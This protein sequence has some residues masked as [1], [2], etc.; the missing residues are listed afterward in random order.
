MQQHRSFNKHDFQLLQKEH[1][2]IKRF[3]DKT[4][5]GASRP[6]FRDISAT[7]ELTSAT[8]CPTEPI[9]LTTSSPHFDSS[10]E[11]MR[12]FLKNLISLVVDIVNKQL[13]R[14]RID[15]FQN[16]VTS[17]PPAIKAITNLIIQMED[18]TLKLPF[19]KLEQ[20]KTQETPLDQ[21]KILLEQ[22][23]ARFEK[24]LHKKIQ[25]HLDVIVYRMIHTNAGKVVDFLSER[26]A[27]L[28]TNTDFPQT[29]DMLWKSLNQIID[30]L[31]IAYKTLEEHQSLLT[32]AKAISSLP[33]RTPEAVTHKDQAA[34]FLDGVGLQP[35]EEVFLAQIFFEQF[36]QLPGCNDTIRKI[37]K[38]SISQSNQEHDPITAKNSIEKSLHEELS[39][40]VISLM[41]PVKKTTLPNGEIEHVD[42]FAQL[43]ESL[44]L[45]KQIN[46]IVKQIEDIAS[47]LVPPE[48]MEQFSSIKKPTTELVKNMLQTAAK[49]LMKKYLAE[50]IGSIYELLTPPEN[51]NTL[52]AETILPVVNDALLRCYIDLE[53]GYNIKSLTP[54][55]TAFLNAD[56]TN[57]DERID[58]LQGK[59]VALVLR[60]NGQ[61]NGKQYFVKENSNDSPILEFT[62]IS[63]Q[64][65]MS[66]TLPII[67]QLKTDFLQKRTEPSSSPITQNEVEKHLTAVYNAPS[68]IKTNPVFGDLVVNLVGELGEFPT[69]KTFSIILKGVFSSLL[70]GATHELSKSHNYLVD[71]VVDAL[72][73][74]ILNKEYLESLI[75]GDPSRP[76]HH[77]PEKLAN[78]IDTLS[79]I[80]YDIIVSA[81]EQQGRIVTFATKTAIGNNSQEVHKIITKSY[82]KL[83]GNDLLNKNTLT[84]L[85]DVILRALAIS[86][87]IIN[88]RE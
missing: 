64:D 24:F 3:P 88:R 85:F 43:C 45:P 7:L 14:S 26:L 22:K 50:I 49:D 78:Q 5:T 84:Q 30:S 10:L 39:Q 60:E 1:A 62:D 18:K 58:S 55:F 9:P 42:S 35:N 32:K 28:L 53:I 51:L 44:Y 79:R 47:T 40:I 4:T 19:D 83:F 69:L 23:I 38:E 80:G 68:L 31:N 16:H 21:K 87:E 86:A 20:E 8:I 65:W 11:K 63:K 33:A 71:L 27:D 54:H 66:L 57:Q 34:K 73:E 75:K 61:F 13:I 59:L 76:P 29:F 70:T 74:T 41:L 17:I 56:P 48:A 6:T 25:Q 12:G 52:M 46:E 2:L 82:N 37:I 72:T 77:I 15:S 67:A 81:V 36:A